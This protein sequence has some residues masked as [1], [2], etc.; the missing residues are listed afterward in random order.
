MTPAGT[1]TWS[2]IHT[3]VQYTT[4][5]QGNPKGSLLEKQAGCVHSDKHAHSPCWRK[6]HPRIWS[7]Y[8]TLCCR[9]L[10]CIHG[11]CGQ[12]RQNGQQLWNCLQNME[13]D[14]ETVFSPNRHDHSKRISYKQVVVAKWCTKIS[15]KFSFVNWLSIHKRKMWQLVAFQGTDQVQLRPS[16]WLEVKHSEHWPSKGKIWRCCMCSLHKQTWSMLYFCW[17]CDDGLCIVNC[18]E[19]W[20]TRLNLSN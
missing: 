1:H 10:Q 8:Q 6:F 2:T 3:E 15:V 5:S 4:M 16:S 7:G 18:F 20:H 14:Q 13:V 11:V 12:V 19:K 9:R 17:K